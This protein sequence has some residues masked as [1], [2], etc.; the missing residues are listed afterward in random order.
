MSE[1][2]YPQGTDPS[3]DPVAQSSLGPPYNPNTGE[4]VDPN[5][6]TWPTFGGSPDGSGGSDLASGAAS[7]DDGG[8]LDSV[9]DFLGGLFG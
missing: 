3:G 5:D 9:L 8:I 2:R 4:P 1:G 6:V 7:G